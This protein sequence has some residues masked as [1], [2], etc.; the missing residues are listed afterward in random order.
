LIIKLFGSPVKDE[1]TVYPSIADFENDCYDLTEFEKSF[2]ELDAKS[3]A[4]CIKDMYYNSI[5]LCQSK[6]YRYKSFWADWNLYG[7]DIKDVPLE[8]DFL[9]RTLQDTAYCNIFYTSDCSLDDFLELSE[10]QER[11]QESPTLLK[12]LERVVWRREKGYRP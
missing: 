7:Y 8:K 9:L 1:I 11:L 2:D 10:V 4:V 3:L 6:Y 12:R 5:A